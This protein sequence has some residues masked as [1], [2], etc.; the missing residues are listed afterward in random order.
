MT[1]SD[2]I[3]PPPRFA[4]AS[5]A[6]KGR[7][8]LVT[9]ASSGIGAAIVK[10]LAA[11]GAGIVASGRDAER[12]EQ[13]IEGIDNASVVPADL[14][15]T[16]AAT[17]LIQDARAAVGTIHGLVNNAGFGIVK[18][19]T[20]LTEADID[21]QMAV[22]VRAAMMLAIQLGEE[23]K[24]IS[25]SAI[26][27]LS[28]I[29]AAVGTPH[30]IAYATSKGAIDAMTRALASELGPAGVRVNAVAPGLTATEMWGKALE[31]KDFLR[32]TADTTALKSWAPPEMIADI[33][34]FLLTD[35]SAYITGE[36]ITAD[37]GFVHTGHLVPEKFFGRS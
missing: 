9:G 20:R 13:A 18:R 36:V 3:A 26:V 14:E 31:S 7:T 30:Q 11:A 5:D 34:C 8:I 15:Q 22:N 6:L 23:L 32:E 33:V 10:R 19:S 17:Q 12:L 21:R 37:G 29:Q 25:G 28:S 16:G 27:N 35:A 4:F 24:A 1:D 2:S